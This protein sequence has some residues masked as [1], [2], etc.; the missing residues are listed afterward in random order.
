MKGCYI[1]PFSKLGTDLQTGHIVHIARSAR[2]QG[3]YILGL[4]GTGKSAL[5]EH[6]IVQD[7]EQGIGL[8]LLDPHG[9]IT[10]RILAYLPFTRKTDVILLEKRTSLNMR[11]VMDEGKILL[12]KPES[13]EKV[14]S[15]IITQIVNAA[16]LRADTPASKRK[17]I[18]LYVDE[19]QRYASEDFAL[20]LTQPARKVGI[21]TTIA[22]QARRQLDNKSRN[23]CLAAGNL[24]VFRVLPEDAHE[25][26]YQFDTKQPTAGEIQAKQQ[27]TRMDI[28]RKIAGELTRLPPFV[29]RVRIARGAKFV[30]YTIQIPPLLQVIELLLNL[31]WNGPAS[32]KLFL[33]K[34]A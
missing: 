28:A 20:F 23:A 26:A 29:A 10:D 11:Q 4:E 13:L 2:L 31:I 32:V 6:L 7:I 15:S 24:I 8:C 18:H 1:I 5:L 16:Y 22:N 25:L 12:I 27:R 19:F 9:N 14:G 30:D 17:Q 21:G 33:L 34:L 3:V